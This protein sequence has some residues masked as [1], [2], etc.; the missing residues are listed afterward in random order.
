M[1]NAYRFISYYSFFQPGSLIQWSSD[2]ATSARV[3]AFK[4]QVIWPHIFEEVG[5]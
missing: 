1:V 3:E 4:S 5:A 2:E